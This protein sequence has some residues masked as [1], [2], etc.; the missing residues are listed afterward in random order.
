MLVWLDVDQQLLELLRWIDGQG[1]WSALWFLAIMALVVVFLLPGVLFTTG[2]GFVFG[3]L[4]GTLYVVIGTTIGACVAFLLA[5]YGAGARAGAFIRRHAGLHAVTREMEAHDFEVVLLTRLV[6]FFPGKLSNYF[7]GLTGFSFRSYS[8][9]T[10]IG[11]VPFSLHNVY[12][13]S[14]AAN[15]VSVDDQA[16]GRTPLEWSIYGIGFV[17]TVV[18]VVTLNRIARRALARFQALPAEEVNP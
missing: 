3:V 1:L 5:R 11:L 13:G 17:A 9:G 10:F 4:E 8:L 2:A 18:A 16:V 14:L 6:P 12:L 7:F 15:L